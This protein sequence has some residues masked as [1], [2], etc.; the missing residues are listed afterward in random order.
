MLSVDVTMS[1]VL[2]A[3]VKKHFLKPGTFIPDAT[4]T[5]IKLSTFPVILEE[6]DLTIL[7]SFIVYLYDK[8]ASNQNIN[9]TRN[10]CLKKTPV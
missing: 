10:F 2:E 7:E 4:E 1:L 5:F 6:K 9:E 3:K 8:S